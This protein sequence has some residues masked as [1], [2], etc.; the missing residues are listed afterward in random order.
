MEWKYVSDEAARHGAR[1]CIC[2]GYGVVWSSTGFA[3]VAS[4]SGMKDRMF[5]KVQMCQ[6]LYTRLL[7][8]R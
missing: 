6:L 3:D 2:N 8:G 4:F 5:F 1:H 7:Y